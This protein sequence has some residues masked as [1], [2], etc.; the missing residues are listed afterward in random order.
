[1]ALMAAPAVILL[2][3]YLW[4]ARHA[5]F[6]QDDFFFIHD[7][8]HT[9]Q[10]RQ[11]ISHENFG[12][13]LSRNFYWWALL[14]TFGRDA[15]AFFLVNLAIM[16]GTSYLLYRLLRQTSRHVALAAGTFYFCCA[17]SIG[18]YSWIC[19]SQHI[20]AHF[21]ILAYLLQIRKLDITRTNTLTYSAS[22]TFFLAISANILAI[23]ALLYPAILISKTRTE[24]HSRQL[25]LMTCIQAMAAI[26]LLKVIRSHDAG[27]YSTAW[28][29]EILKENLDFYFG[30]FWFFLAACSLLSYH[31]WQKWQQGDA[32]TT[33]LLLSGPAFIL[34]FIA[35]S[36]QRYLNY[37]ALSHTL[38]FTALALSLLKL[39]KKVPAAIL[40]TLVLNHS[41]HQTQDQKSYFS[42]NQRGVREREIL[43]A[44]TTLLKDLNPP[45]DS[46]ICVSK[47]GET[48]SPQAQMPG[49]WWGLA[50]GQAFDVYLTDRIIYQLHSKAETCDYDFMLDTLTLVHS[51]SSSTA[52]P[53]TNQVQGEP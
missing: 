43:T 9:L 2:T 30:S 25:W 18:N 45:N 52:T 7:Y 15:Q 34:P 16:A 20:L 6:Y 8:E 39:P 24:K 33:W 12:R 22:L 5:W 41:I 3:F 38:T 11:L 10:V 44:A 23:V 14:Q 4:Y 46:K 36:Q 17:P 19:N 1:M 35:L 21:L 32:F 48:Y 37:A 40:L 26:T 51:N 27:P 49:F 53:F 31:A 47:H 29:P 42:E 13:F 28:T 50:F